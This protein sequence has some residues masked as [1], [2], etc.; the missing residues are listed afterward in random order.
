VRD[1]DRSVRERVFG[2]KGYSIDMHTSEAELEELRTMVL[3]HW[4]DRLGTRYS[5]DVV[6]EFRIA[7]IDQYHR[8]A[9]R[10]DH[11]ALWT[12]TARLFSQANVLRIR[13]MSFFRTLEQTFGQFAISN[14]EKIHPEEIYWRIVRPG[15]PMDIGPIHADAWYWELGH[16]EMPA[17]AVRI[18]VWMPL[19]CEPGLSG[20]K[21]LAGSHMRSW[22]YRAER[23]DGQVKP[24]GTF[25]ANILPMTLLP[26]RPGT[27]VVFHDRL[28]HGGALNSGT[29]TRMSAEFTILASK[30]NL[31]ALGCDLGLDRESGAARAA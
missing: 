5:F 27:L 26:T 17:D 16:G 25:D 1:L 30:K 14:E 18:K 13:R 23:W 9:D 7:G 21:V 22:P 20:L 3:V 29:V 6:N 24:R 12:K 11:Q 28:L 8:L 10:V 15:V 19:Y 31:Q 4:L 2:A